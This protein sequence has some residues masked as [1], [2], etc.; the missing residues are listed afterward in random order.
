MAWDLGEP[1]EVDCSR[2]PWF[3]PPPEPGFSPSPEKTAMSMLNDHVRYLQELSAAW[4]AKYLIGWPPDPTL[5]G[6]DNSE[7]MDDLLLYPQGFVQEMSN[8]HYGLSGC[9]SFYEATDDLVPHLR[10]I[11]S[12][13]NRFP[14]RVTPHRGPRFVTHQRLSEAWR[15]A[16]NSSPPP[17]P[18]SAG[19]GWLV[20]ADGRLIE[21]LGEY[22]AQGQGE[23]DAPEAEDSARLRLPAS[24]TS[25]LFELHT[26]GM[27]RYHK[28]AILGACLIACGLFGI[29][30]VPEHMSDIVRTAPG[31]SLLVGMYQ[32]S[33]GRAGACQGQLARLVSRGLFRDY[34]VPPRQDAQ[35]RVAGDHWPL[36]PWFI[37][38]L[39]KRSASALVLLG[40]T[41]ALGAAFHSALLGSALLSLCVLAAL[42][43]WV[44]WEVRNSPSSE[45]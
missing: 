20:F 42:D 43:T 8:P 6:S 3:S 13:H 23:A 25:F 7:N 39:V 12:D 26:K 9:L 24:M 2:L 36:A 19:L 4:K 38:G 15:V 32:F 45:W 1:V 34:R 33:C 28:Q 16:A 5:T 41:F 14:S 11:W 30:S 44:F 22:V 18:T 17:Q 21:I 27:R 10:S 35:S 40:L 37:Q 29:F 31:I